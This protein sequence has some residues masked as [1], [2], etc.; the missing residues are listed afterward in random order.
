MI[1]TAFLVLHVGAGA[2]ALASGLTLMVLPGKGNDR[3]RRI[4]RMFGWSMAVSLAAAVVLALVNFSSF[5]LAIAGFSAYLLAAGWRAARRRKA[6]PGMADRLI[7]GL[8]LGLGLVMI[9][10][11]LTGAV[12][13]AANIVMPIFGVIGGALACQDLMEASRV[14][15]RRIA[16]HLSRMMGALIGTITAALVVNGPALGLP[17]IAAWLV[18]TVL[19]VPAIVW[20][21]VRL[22]RASGQG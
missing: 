10:A 8:M 20:W 1:S 17:P 6:E 2:L 5:L 12:G 18:P 13:G 4:G 22:R 3:H 14:G 11:G 7:A 19:V 9:V 15:P 21:N 16:R